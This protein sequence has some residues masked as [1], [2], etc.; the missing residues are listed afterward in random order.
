MN[1]E[2]VRRNGKIQTEIKTERNL[3]YTILR[4]MIHSLVQ[5]FVYGQKSG[6]ESLE[7]YQMYSAK[8]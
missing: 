1:V 3:I 7:I 4:K 5:H 2:I 6:V 8:F